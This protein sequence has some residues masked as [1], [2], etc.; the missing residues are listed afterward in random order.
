M[1]R[2]RIIIYIL[3]FILLLAGFLITMGFKDAKQCLGNP[4]IYGIN[5]LENK[6]T[7]NLYCTCNFQNQEYA[8]FSFNNKEVAVITNL[9]IN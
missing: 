7:G 3:C 8:P 4:F 5:Q 2:E 9:L 6:D 1:K